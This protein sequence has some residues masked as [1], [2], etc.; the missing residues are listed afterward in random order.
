MR[1]PC[2]KT[3]YFCVDF[4]YNKSEYFSAEQGYMIFNI[5]DTVKIKHDGKV[6]AV[7]SIEQNGDAT[8]YIVLA[9][10]KKNSLL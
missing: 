2:R 1:R 7:V 8:R 3:L 6:G 9:D 4:C 10:G 5:G